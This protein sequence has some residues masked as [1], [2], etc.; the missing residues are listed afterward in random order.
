MAFLQNLQQQLGLGQQQTAGA[1]KILLLG[2]QRKVYVEGRKRFVII[3][4][5]KVS[6]TQARQMDKAYK[7]EKKAKK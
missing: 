1:P 2:R 5:E 4:G 6:I 3:K 7:A